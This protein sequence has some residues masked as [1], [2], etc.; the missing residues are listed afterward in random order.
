MQVYRVAA[1]IVP[2][3]RMPH[4]RRAHAPVQYLVP[5]RD[6]YV[7]PSLSVGLERWLGPYERMEIDAP[8][9]VRY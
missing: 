8:H 5:T 1:N 4:E 9:W 6:R 7:H 2:R 3:L